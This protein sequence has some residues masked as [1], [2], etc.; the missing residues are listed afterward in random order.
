M[1]RCRLAAITSTTALVLIGLASPAA[2]VDGCIDT[3][4]PHVGYTD[5]FWQAPDLAIRDVPLAVPVEVQLPDSPEPP[6]CAGMTMIVQ[7]ADG[8]LRTE[9]P[10]NRS[11]GSGSPPR[12]TA[13]GYLSVPVAD[14]AGTWVIT[15]VTHGANSRAAHVPFQVGRA[16]VITLDQPATVT[17]PGK[18]TVTGSVRRYTSTGSLVASPARAVRIVHA[19]QVQVVA[20]TTTDASGR[21]RVQIPFTRTTTMFADTAAKGLFGSARTGYYRTAHRR[22]ALTALSASPN[23]TVNSFWKVT[24]SAFPGKLATSLQY[25]N[26][27]SWVPTPSGGYTAADGSFARYWKPT[28][29]GTFRVR[30]SLEGRGLDNNLLHKEM[31]VTVRQLPQQPTYVS[32]TV[33]PT[34]GGPVKKG[35]KMS[36]FGRLEILRADGTVGPLA[37]EVVLVQLKRPSETTWTTYSGSRTTSTGYHYANWDVPFEAGETFSVAVTYVT[38]LPRGAS[39]SRIIRTYT[40]L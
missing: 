18:T 5:V 20:N 7:K 12:F 32:G 2:A 1:K 35:V 39:S 14:G 17:G 33:G 30:L 29:A 26:G 21:Y 13:Y 15:K 38:T 27:V 11:G 25:W 19:N 23:A 9:V 10:L 36:T 4:G 22:M 16:S 37:G 40:V 28:K 34:A 31:T 24:G 8:S 6:S 3:Y